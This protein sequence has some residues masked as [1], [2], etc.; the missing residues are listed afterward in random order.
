MGSGKVQV[1]CVYSKLH[2][3]FLA[4]K[5]FEN[6]T[7]E[8]LDDNEDEFSEEDEIAIELYRYVVMD[9]QSH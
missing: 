4:V 8:E 9:T 1:R 7:L 5:T 3:L 6:M 2:L